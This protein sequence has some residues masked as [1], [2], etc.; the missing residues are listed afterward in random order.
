M[1]LHSLT[2]FVSVDWKGGARGKGILMVEYLYSRPLQ[3]GGRDFGC[4]RV[5][6]LGETNI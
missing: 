2:G 5:G 6:D 1:G 3:G 4:A